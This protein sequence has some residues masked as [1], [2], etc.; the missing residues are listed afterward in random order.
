MDDERPVGLV[1]VA[2]HL[3][4]SR[5]RIRQLVR[6][7][8]LRSPRYKLGGHGNWIWKESDLDELKSGYAAY[9]DNL[10]PQYRNRTR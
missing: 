2:Q 10:A 6:D 3:G 9:A 8:I 7:G 1:E 4:L 5:N